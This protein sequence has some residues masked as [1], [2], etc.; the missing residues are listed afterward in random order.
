MTC[1]PGT[2]LK[3]NE[4]KKRFGSLRN[5]DS[6]NSGE[7]ISDI[8]SEEDQELT[9]VSVLVSVITQKSSETHCVNV[10]N[11]DIGNSYLRGLIMFSHLMTHNITWSLTYMSV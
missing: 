6:E 11:K 9:P 2:N 8:Q 1:W 4:K 7:G 5:R 10:T 3:Q